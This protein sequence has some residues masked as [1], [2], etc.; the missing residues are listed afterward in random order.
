LD[1]TG[2]KVPTQARE[3]GVIAFAFSA[4]GVVGEGVGRVALV[5]E[6]VRLGL[7]VVLE[8]AFAAC[9]VEGLARG[10]VIEGVVVVVTT[11]LTADQA[12]RK[13]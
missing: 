13:G 12:K 3:G 7:S 10:I 9:V 1:E 4:V 8:G 2:T 11:A 6:R 5:L